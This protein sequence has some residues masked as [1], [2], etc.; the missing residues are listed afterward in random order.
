ML[1]EHIHQ[2]MGKNLQYIKL[3][4]SFIEEFTEIVWEKKDCRPYLHIV[5]HKFKPVNK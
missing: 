2:M 5:I 3:F 1:T 4:P